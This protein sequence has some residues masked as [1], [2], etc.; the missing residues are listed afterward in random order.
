MS[1]QGR[2]STREQAIDELKARMASLIE[3]NRAEEAS[4]MRPVVNRAL[5]GRPSLLWLAWAWLTWRK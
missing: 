2:P 4:E 3:Q 5:N 1:A